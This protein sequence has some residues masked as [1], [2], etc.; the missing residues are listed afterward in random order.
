MCD[1]HFQV[2]EVQPLV[3]AAEPNGIIN[4][5]LVG[6]TEQILIHL[7]GRQFLLNS[8]PEG[9]YRAYLPEEQNLAIAGLENDRLFR[10]LFIGEHQQGHVDQGLL[11]L[12]CVHRYF[13]NKST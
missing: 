6:A 7:F 12:C 10:D 13:L 11:Q 1:Q 9:F 2:F 5:G 4:Q 3:I 8:R